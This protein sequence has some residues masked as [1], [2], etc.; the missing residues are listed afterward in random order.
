K[1]YEGILRQT[2][3]ID[4]TG[5]VAKVWEKVKAEDHALEVAQALEELQRV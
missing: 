5:H 3:L 4:P 2:F 1:E